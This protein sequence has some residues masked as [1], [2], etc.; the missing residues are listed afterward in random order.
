MSQARLRRCT[1]Q[2]LH[3]Q[4]QLM[5]LYLS[6]CLCFMASGARR[7]V[8]VDLSQTSERPWCIMS[9]RNMALDCETWLDR[10]TWHCI[11]W[12]CIMPSEAKSV[13]IACCTWR[14]TITKFCGETAF[15]DPPWVPRDVCFALTVASLCFQNISIT[16]MQSERALACEA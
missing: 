3:H 1:K 16:L 6:W 15:I 4:Q 14:I 8:G 11:I 10:C 12:H 5:H 13:P 9:W 7:S 2:P